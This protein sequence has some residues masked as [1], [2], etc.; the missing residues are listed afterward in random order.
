MGKIRLWLPPLLCLAARI[1]AGVPAGHPFVVG[2]CTHFSQNK[3]DLELNLE[4]LRQAG[5]DSIRDELGWSSVERSKGRLAV[6]PGRDAYLHRAAALG[7]E[8]LLILDYGNRFYDGGRHPRSDEAIE[9]F[10]RYAEFLVKHLGS[11]VRL[12]EIW[13]EWDIGIGLPGRE[14][15]SAADY[16]RLLKAVAPRIRAADPKAII[17]GAG[18]PTSGGINRGWLEELVKLGALAHCDI[19]SIHTYNYSPPGIQG[20]PEAWLRWT[21]G[22]QEMLRKYN[23]GK[24]VPFYITEM[25]WPSHAGPRGRP[26]DV[27]AAYLARMF[28][29]ARTLPYLRGIWWYDFQD[30]GWNREYNEDNFGLVRPDLTPKPAFHALADI[31]GLVRNGKYLGRLDAGERPI[32]IL[33]FRLGGREVWAAW[34]ADDRPWQLVLERG[35]PAPGE[36][37][38]VR[39][40]GRRPVAASWGHRDWAERRGA[41]MDPGQFS[42]V[43]GALPTLLTGEGEAGLPGGV[44]VKSVRPRGASE[45]K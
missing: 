34:S 18:G 16:F 26:A 7:I 32:W 21:E 25:G 41:G 44:R 38:E 8:P 4:R 33:R 13:N 42:L 3:G 11:S 6:P 24:D 15:G 23:G 30:D 5:I 14:R 17:L 37:L 36:K 19:L 29:L 20:G 2:A 28:L 1:P 39:Q 31:A 9:G 10:C 35:S 22:V 45:E 43:V 12:Y 27:C 40:A